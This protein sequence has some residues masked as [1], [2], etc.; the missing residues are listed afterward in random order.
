MEKLQIFNWLLGS[1]NVKYVPQ[2]TYHHW[3]KI[4]DTLL[5]CFIVKYDGDGEPDISVGFSI[6][7]SS[8]DSAILSLRDIKWKFLSANDQEIVFKNEVT[9]KSANVKWALS[10]ERKTWQSVISGEKNLEIVNLIKDENINL[11]NIVKEFVVQHPEVIKAAL[12]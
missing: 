9:P 3:L 6:K 10:N 4:N 5:M 7:Y 2:I 1:W 8:S 12:D 11:E